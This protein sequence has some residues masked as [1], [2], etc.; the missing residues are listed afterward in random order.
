MELS[1]TVALSAA[2]VVGEVFTAL[3]ILLFVLIAEVLEKK[4][5]ERGRH[6]LHALTEQLPEL[7]EVRAESGIHSKSLS[8]V[9]KGE[10]VVIRP[11]RLIPVDGEVVKGNSFVDQSAITGESLPVEKLPGGDVYAGTLNHLGLLEVMVL[12]VGADT[13]FGKIIEAVEHAE[14]SRA[15]CN[16]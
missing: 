4:T 9:V 2:L 1:M 15:R 10:I 8:E 14:Q 6:A 3:V 5:V 13:A 12:K 11:G 16:G 7:V